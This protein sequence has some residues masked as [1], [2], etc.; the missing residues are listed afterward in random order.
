VLEVVLSVAGTK[1]VQREP[2]HRGDLFGVGHRVPSSLSS[3][4]HAGTEL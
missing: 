4:E 1:V 3:A 2:D